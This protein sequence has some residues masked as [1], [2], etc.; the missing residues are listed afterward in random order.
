VALVLVLIGIYGVMSYAASRR[1]R[2]I[3]IRMALGA[4]RADTLRLLLAGG[5]RLIAVGLVAG[6]AAAVGLT[7]VLAGPLYQ[8]S[9]TDP[10]TFMA[11]AA[12]LAAVAIAAC[13]GPAC[14]ALAIDPMEA[15]RRD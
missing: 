6:S 10:L 14:K 15:L 5:V 2:E 8:V 7:R 11:V 13:L 9:P 12:I 4:G 1:A 3:A